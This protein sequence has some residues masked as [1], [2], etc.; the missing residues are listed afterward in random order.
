MDNDNT[1]KSNYEAINFIEEKLESL[2]ENLKFILTDKIKTMEY[3]KA[4]TIFTYI[5][6]EVNL[7][8]NLFNKISNIKQ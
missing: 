5:K 2:K 1:K 7:L 8:S 6:S 3:E 4:K